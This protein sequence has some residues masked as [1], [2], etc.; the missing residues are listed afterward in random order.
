MAQTRAL[1]PA[2]LM[3]LLDDRLWNEARRQSVAPLL[4][5]QPIRVRVKS[6][7]MYPLLYAIHQALHILTLDMLVAK[8]I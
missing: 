4:G 7:Y 8:P 3:R 5:C 1:S 6:M 2:S